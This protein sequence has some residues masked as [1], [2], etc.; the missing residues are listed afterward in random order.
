MKILA[1][2]LARGGSKRLPKKNIKLLDGKPLIVWSI[3]VVENLSE[4]CDVLV[5]TDCPII[6]DIASEHGALVPWLRPDELATD[7]ATSIDAAIHAV[8]WYENN[9]CQVDGILLLQPTSPFRSEKTVIRA[10]NEFKSDFTAP[11]V[12]MSPVSDHPH[13]C[14]QIENN[15]AIPFCSNE[16]INTRSQDLPPVYIVNGLI[17]L[18]SSDSLKKS[19]SFYNSKTRALIVNNEYEALDID[20]ANDWHFANFILKQDLLGSKNVK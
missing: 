18:S 9:V 13:W 6:A 4:V 11:V 17:Y 16:S 2:I 10:L 1:L 5:S 7:T 14:F 20:D 12:A 15:T 19:K 8:D 3:D